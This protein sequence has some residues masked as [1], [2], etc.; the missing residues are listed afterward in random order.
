M[1]DV[2]SAPGLF[3]FLLKLVRV[4]FLSPVT[5][6]LLAKT[7]AIRAKIK[8]ATR[9]RQ[10]YLTEARVQWFPMVEGASCPPKHML[11]LPHVGLLL[12]TGCPAKDSI[13]HLLLMPCI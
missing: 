6:K 9:S 11:P 13:S 1:I 7:V 10:P 12:G 2:I 5:K 3:P 8:L 4:G